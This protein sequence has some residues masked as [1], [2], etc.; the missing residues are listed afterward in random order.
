MANL[1][2]FDADGNEVY[3]KMLGAGTDLDPFKPVQDVFIQDQATQQISLYLGQNL[4]ENVTYRA[5]QPGNATVLNITSD[6]APAVG[7]FICSKEGSFFT[8]PEIIS[9]TSLGGNDYDVGIAMPLDHAY[10]TSA[11]LCLQ[12]CDMNVDG[13][14]TPIEFVLGPEGLAAGEQW[15][16]TRMIVVMTHSAAGD[17][18]RFGGLSA[19]TNGTY[20]RLENG[21]N[22]NLFN[23]KEN[24]DFAIEGYDIVYP[25]R[26]AAGSSYGTRAR[27]T[28][29]GQD[30]RGVVLRLSVDT[31]DQVLACVRDDLS[32]LVSFRVKFQGQVTDPS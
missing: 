19:L 32:G 30:K 5:A 22:Y 25:T 2:M 27:I 29:N 11:H 16:L 20:F 26:A 31:N 28:F 1:K 13:S 9:V 6:V 24:G 14:T 10:T 8:Q 17:D 4:T 7:N 18:S 3:L 12:N 21:T 23:A 15:D